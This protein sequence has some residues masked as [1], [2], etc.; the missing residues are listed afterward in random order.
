M[1]DI[2]AI[3]FDLDGTLVQT[4]RLKAQSYARAAVVL[5]EN[6]ALEAEAIKA[7][8]QVVGRSRHEVADFLLSRLNLR[9]AAQSQMDKWR[10]ETPA[11]AFIAIRLAFYQR[12]IA[13]RSVMQKSIWPHNI[14]ALQRAAKEGYKTG[15]ATMSHR[16]Q[17]TKV[18]EMLELTGCF[19]CIAT[20]D[21]VGIGKPDPEIY[22][23]VSSQLQV[24]PDNCLVFE[25]SIAG[26]QAALAAGMQVIAV[27]T[28]FT[29]DSLIQA[30]ALPPDRM[31]HD[32]ALLPE[33]IDC[34]LGQTQPGL[35]T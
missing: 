18:L 8:K 28:P 19:Q 30:G 23:L 9:E 12:M 21:D 11:E 35:V 31:I 14:A 25:D 34:I 13:D 15:L 6:E 29:Y 20:R 4:E 1:I 16:E 5:T 2:E 7:F 32:P 10:V 3:L 24:E 33:A 26:V 27:S 22:H 17:A